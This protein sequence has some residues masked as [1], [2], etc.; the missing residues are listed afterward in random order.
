MVDATDYNQYDE[1][2]NHYPMDYEARAI[3]TAVEAMRGII[4]ARSRQAEG[5][6]Q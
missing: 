3:E 2:H 6:G 4:R 5:A 1:D